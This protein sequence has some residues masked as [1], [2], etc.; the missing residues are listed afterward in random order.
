MNLIWYSLL[1]YDLALL[2]YLWILCI[3]NCSHCFIAISQ[4]ARLESAQWHHPTSAWKPYEAGWTVRSESHRPPLTLCIK[5]SPFWHSS[6]ESLIWHR[7]LIIISELIILLYKKLL[8]TKTRSD[9]GVRPY[10]EHSLIFH[11][12]ASL[13]ITKF[14][15][16]YVFIM[17]L[18]LFSLRH[19]VALSGPST[20][21]SSMALSHL[22]SVTSRSSHG[23]TLRI[24]SPFIDTVYHHRFDITYKLWFDFNVF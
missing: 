21:I 5:I 20:R 7:L 10:N 4:S 11:R 1:I 22:S 8:Y 6:K 24:A 18:P 16:K 19:F 14:L 12:I 3:F 2:Y 9:E 23:C 17:Y 13:C 15:I